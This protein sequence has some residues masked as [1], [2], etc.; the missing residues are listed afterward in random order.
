MAAT[1]EWIEHAPPLEQRWTRPGGGQRPSYD[2]GVDGPAAGG[3]VAYHQVGGQDRSQTRGW[4]SANGSAQRDHCS[5][6]RASVEYGAS[7]AVKGGWCVACGAADCPLAG[8]PHSG[9]GFARNGIVGY[10]D[11]ATKHFEIRGCIM[12]LRRLI[13]GATRDH[14]RLRMSLLLTVAGL[15]A[16]AVWHVIA[17]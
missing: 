14:R 15:A 11:K 12:P 9:S 8:L 5:P 2:A 7:A 10:G 17:N 13:D 4:G 3:S 16:W 6:G 1:T